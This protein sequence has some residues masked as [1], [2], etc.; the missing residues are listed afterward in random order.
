MEETA[1]LFNFGNDPAPLPSKSGAL[2]KAVLLFHFIYDLL[3]LSLGSFSCSC[4]VSFKTDFLFF[5]TFSA[6]AEPA[7]PFF[8]SESPT[9]DGEIAFSVV[10][11]VSA[12]YVNILTRVLLKA[13]RCNDNSR[14]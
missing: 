11:L 13:F 5:V 10:L 6:A 2:V 8:G 7:D 9:N 3:A 4:A 1:D 14:I 12:K